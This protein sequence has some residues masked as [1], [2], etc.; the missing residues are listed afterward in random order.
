MTQHTYTGM[1]NVKE[2]KQCKAFRWHSRLCQSP[3]YLTPSCI[4]VL[5]LYH[6]DFSTA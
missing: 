4:D 2:S 6:F 1:R 5:L 3:V